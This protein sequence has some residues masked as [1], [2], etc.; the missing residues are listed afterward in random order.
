LEH[1]KGVQVGHRHVE[2][3]NVGLLTKEELETRFT[4][5]CGEHLG[6]LPLELRTDLDHIAQVRIVVHDQDLHGVASAASDAAI[7]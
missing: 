7:S 1:F 2:Q 5:R 4:V 3:D 6:V